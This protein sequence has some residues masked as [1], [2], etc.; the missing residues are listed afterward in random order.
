MKNTTESAVIVVA[1]PDDE[2]IWCG[3]YILQHLDRQWTVLSL[4]RQ[5]DSDR[6]PKFEK[7]CNLLGIVGHIFDLNDSNPLRPIDFE[8]IA[9]I[10][11]KTISVRA[12]DMCF[13]HGTNGEYGHMR[14]KQVGSTVS[15]LAKS[16][17]LICK[18]LWRFAYD[19]NADNGACSPLPTA[20]KL[21]HLSTGQLSEKR[22]IVREI[23]GYSE[24]SFEVRAC[25]SPEAFQSVGKTRKE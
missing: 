4:C 7:V 13:T 22:R 18:N 19:C 21:I 8:D 15:R 23:Y 14:H 1:H 11:R 25:I 5:D 6:R 17:D 9:K 2:I 12:W 16:G 3:G 10:I 20:D 24:D